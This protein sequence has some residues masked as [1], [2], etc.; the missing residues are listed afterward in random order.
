MSSF[1]KNNLKTTKLQ[2][3]INK[4]NYYK[5]NNNI[6][7]T[8]YFN[9]N[10]SICIHCYD[11]KIFNE[12][13]FYIKNFFEFKWKR[14]QIIIHYV[15]INLKIIENIIEKVF[16]NT[17]TIDICD[18]FIF[19][20]GKNIGGD[21]GGFL[22]CSEFIKIDDDL[23]SIIHTKT[24]DSWR[25]HLMNI[26]TK[27]GIYTSVKLLKK[28]D[29][30]M[31][32]SAYNTEFFTKKFN[33]HFNI[34]QFHIPMIQNICD[35]IQFPFN[36][37]NL[38]KSYFVAGTIFICK[39]ELLIHIIHKRNLIYDLCLDLDKLYS[40]DKKRPKNKTYEHSMEIMFGYIPYQM[41]QNLVGIY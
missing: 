37:E 35:L 1:K 16:E 2:N 29:I 21:I 13:M 12:L 3:P 24:D 4:I 18:C 36:L 28:K 33:K 39:K 41:K 26:F 20:K 5:I 32:G 19:T 9:L 30:G 34:N 23:V 10:I 8:V 14:I 7:K 38:I 11:F 17:L 31:I 40:I 6:P 27:E 22:R 15:N 25:K